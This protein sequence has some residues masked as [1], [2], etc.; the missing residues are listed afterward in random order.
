MNFNF[1]KSLL[2]L[3]LVGITAAASAQNTSSDSTK[4]FQKREF[5]TWSIGLN[6]G[7]LDPH[8]PFNGETNGDFKN[9]QISWG[10]GAYVKKQILPGFGIQADFLAGTVK[11]V[12]ANTLPSPST[13]QDA[14]SF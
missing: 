10:Y 11:G 14:S 5:R 7:M 3:S 4:R 9:P 12:R 8:T 2:A 13:A 1:T 6:G